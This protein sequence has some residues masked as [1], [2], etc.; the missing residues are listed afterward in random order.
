[1]ITTT[2]L[3]SA[4]CKTARL[5][6]QPAPILDFI[7]YPTAT[8]FDPASF[9]FVTSVRECPVKL[10]DASDGRVRILIIY[11]D[12]S[13]INTISCS[14]VLHIGSL[15]IESDRLPRI[16]W[17]SILPR[18]SWFCVNISRCLLIMFHPRLYCGFEDAIELFDLSRPGEGTRLHTT[19]SKKCK[20]GLKGTLFRPTFLDFSFTTIS[21]GLSLLSPSH[22]HITARNFSMLLE[23]SCLR[24]P[25]LLCLATNKNSL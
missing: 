11:S 13:L 16:V 15:T 19:P 24:L 12:T 22:P 21:K 4:I 23:V 14:F 9:C 6:Y 20:D 1:M 17:S 8:P 7:W 3:H 18:R 25:T 2:L 5:F 10:L